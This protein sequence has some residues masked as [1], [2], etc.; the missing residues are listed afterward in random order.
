VALVEGGVFSCDGL[1]IPILSVED[2]TH[3]TLAYAWPGAGNGNGQ[4]YAI[5]RTP[6]EA[7]ARAATWTVDR[8]GKLAQTPW[9]VGVVP[10]GRGTLAQ[11]NALNPMPNDDY[12]WLRVEVDQPLEYYFRVAGQWLGPY[13]L[14]GDA[15]DVPGPPGGPGPAG[16]PNTLTIGTVQGGDTAD[17]EI[18]GSAPNQELNLTLPKGN[19]GDAGSNGWTPILAV[20]ADGVRRVQQVID[21]T[22]G[23]DAKPATG[24]YVGPSGFVST[25]AAAVDIRGASGSGTG[26]AM[27][28]GGNQFAGNQRIDGNLYVGPAAGAPISPVQFDSKVAI[29]NAITNGRL[30]SGGGGQRVFSLIDT[31]AV[32]RLWRPQTGDV[33]ASVEMAVGTASENITSADIPWWDFG[34][35]SQNRFFIRQRTGSNNRTYLNVDQ[36]GGVAVGNLGASGS[37]AD[38]SAQFEV[39]S[40]E[41]GLLPPRMTTAQREAIASPA[42]GLVVY[43]TSLSATM[44]YNGSLWRRIATSP[45]VALAS[46]ADLDTLLD[47]NVY[48]MNTNA[49]AAAGSNFPV[50]LAGVLEVIETTSSTTSHIQRYT[51]YRQGGSRCFIRTR[52]GGA[53]PVW[54]SWWE[55]ASTAPATTTAAGLM[56]SADKSKLD[57]VSANANQ[58]NISTVGA[59]VAGANSQETL[60]DGDTLSGVL[61]GTSTLFRA[62]WGNIKAALKTYFDT[63]YQAA[64]SYVPTTRTVATQHS[65]QGGG[66]LSANRTLSLAGDVASPGNNKVYGTDASGE[67][68]WKD[69]PAGGGIGVDQT[70]Q[71]VTGSRVVA[72]A[73]Q[74]LTGKVIA[75]SVTQNGSTAASVRS[76]EISEN[77][78]AWTSLSRSFGQYDGTLFAIIRPNQY[79]RVIAVSGTATI[80]SW[81]E[82]R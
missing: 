29:G 1:S 81:M 68:G 14:K 53:S 38:A 49:G 37:N 33:A 54:G 16:P 26:D 5:A 18:T 20:V 72:T 57:T 15:S 10:D 17:A 45:P 69:D 55:V 13:V 76:L 11:R 25:S 12:C 73:Y 78:S 80:T 36:T 75:V 39:R 52:S 65:L 24:Q 67:R 59:A 51:T 4:Q 40:T 35:T 23:I 6:S 31:A 82:L 22:G 44:V 8:L 43:D 70:W 50:P 34:L 63:I 46:G 66:N 21:W 64:G 41:R 28:A 58:T 79:Y 56:S 32:L 3:L 27:L 62:T 7:T 61:S 2:D 60:A 48:S 77:G 74:N 19:R 71:D 9:G 47:P 42:A 30:T